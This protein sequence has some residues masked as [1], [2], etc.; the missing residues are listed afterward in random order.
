MIGRKKEKE[1]KKDKI[2]SKTAWVMEKKERGRNK[3]QKNEIKCKR[4]Q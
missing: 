4:K 2:T 1:S 3:E